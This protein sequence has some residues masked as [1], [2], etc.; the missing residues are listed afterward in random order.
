M[1]GVLESVLH[2]VLDMPYLVIGFFVNSI[3]GLIVSV[4]ALAN[5][6]LSLLPSFPSVPSAP[7]GVMG[8]VLWAFP[9]GTMVAVWTTFVG[10][11]VAFLGFKVAM[12]WVKLL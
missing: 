1:I 6:I 8:A 3:N 4:A 12:K 5:L 11:W 9:L 7:G 10:L 2:G